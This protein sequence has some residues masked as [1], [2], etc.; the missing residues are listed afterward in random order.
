VAR[1]LIVEDEPD[2]ALALA[3]DLS[4]EGYDTDVVADGEAAIARGM[5]PG[6]DLILLDVMLPRVDGFDVCRR[7]RRAG[8][9]TPIVMLTARAQEAEKIMGLELGADDYVTKPFSPRE[10]RAR[11]KAVLRRGTPVGDVYAFGDVEVDFSRAEVRR[12]GSAIDIT[13]LE[14]KLLEAFI[15]RRGRVLTR[16]QLLDA[17]WDTGVHV[18]DRAVDAHIVNLRRKIEPD[19]AAPRY[20]LSV[21]GLGY[22]FDG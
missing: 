22:R 4:A 8:V 1:I 3:H 13:P 2:I 21:R 11:I 14:L 5:Q 17:A 20:V 9:T 10:L 15:R 7:L 18:T 19:A 12:A 16:D 6:L